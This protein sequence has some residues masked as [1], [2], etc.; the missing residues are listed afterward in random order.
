MDQ[1]E[2]LRPGERQR[3]A[4]G[5][6]GTMNRSPPVR[7]CVSVSVLPYI[8]RLHF[9]FSGFL[10]SGKGSLFPGWVTWG[11]WLHLSE[12]Q[13]L[14]RENQADSSHLPRAMVRI[15]ALG[16]RGQWPLCRVGA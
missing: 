8:S 16:E 4:Q 9:S 6:L 2:K 14:P 10:I 11:Q 3:L 12:P 7:L 5:H 13:P 1:M 15:Q